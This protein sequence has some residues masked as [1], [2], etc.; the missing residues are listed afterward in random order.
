M[1]YDFLCCKKRDIFKEKCSLFD[2]LLKVD[3]LLT[4]FE[5]TRCILIEQDVHQFRG[6][7]S[8]ITNWES[9]CP[10]EE[11]IISGNFL[12]FSE[13]FKSKS[14]S[15]DDIHN[16][17]IPI[18][19]FTYCRSTNILLLNIGEQLLVA[20]DYNKLKDELEEKNDEI[21]VLKE[22]LKAAKGLISCQANRLV[23]TSSPIIEKKP[24]REVDLV[25]ASQDNEH[26]ETQV[27]SCYKVPCVYH[28][29]N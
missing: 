9:D 18:Q 3:V 21:Q 10:M 16:Y 2:K 24:T 26:S 20:R 6:Q 14:G 4:S 8:R 22:E 11:H 29:I 23:I 5:S 19:Y 25:D 7:T 1:A 13:L 27:I 28:N 15:T 17:I 12:L